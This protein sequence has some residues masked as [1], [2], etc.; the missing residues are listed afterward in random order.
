[1]SD[2][3][4]PPVSGPQVFGKYLAAILAGLPLGWLIGAM[5]MAALETIF[6]RVPGV[7]LVGSALLTMAVIGSF[8]GDRLEKM[9]SVSA[10][11][12][13]LIAVAL[14]PGGALAA[15]LFLLA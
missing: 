1:M 15:V 13:L 4:I 2:R 14:V 12:V 8:L 6:D 3:P 11:W 10:R 9:H 5:V 7:V